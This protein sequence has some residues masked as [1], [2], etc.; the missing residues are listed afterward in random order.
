MASLEPLTL[1]IPVSFAT[2]VHTHAIRTR[3]PARDWG[4]RLAGLPTEV[5]ARDSKVYRLGL[6]TISGYIRW[7]G[8]PRAAALAKKSRWIRGLDGSA[9]K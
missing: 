4:T 2:I 9:A 8:P 7:H 6:R 1:E 5:V 3:C